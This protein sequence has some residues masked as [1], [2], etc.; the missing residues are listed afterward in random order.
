MFQ[1]FT[2]YVAWVFVEDFLSFLGMKVALKLSC[3]AILWM[4]TA[5]TMVWVYSEHMEALNNVD[6][7]ISKL[8][9][10]LNK[11]EIRHSQQ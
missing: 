6:K 5:L 11:L 8:V 3:E 4:R 7:Q 1:C 10:P 2:T 9:S